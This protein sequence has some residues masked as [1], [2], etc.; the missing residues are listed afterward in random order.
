[1][2]NQI[3]ISPKVKVPTLISTQR[4]KSKDPLPNSSQVGAWASCLLGFAGHQASRRRK[5][6]GLKASV[7]KRFQGTGSKLVVL[8]RGEQRRATSA[9][10]YLGS[11]L[12]VSPSYFFLWGTN[13]GTNLVGCHVIFR[14]LY[15]PSYTTYDLGYSS[16]LLANF[17]EHPS[18]G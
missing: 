3:L 12:R 17:A 13:L 8:T 10:S 14:G 5:P 2:E 15:N 18:I 11:Q 7:P 1:M 9:G 16:N 4:L 6:P